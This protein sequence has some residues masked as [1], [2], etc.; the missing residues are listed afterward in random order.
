M[1]VFILYNSIPYEGGYVYGVYSTKL[2]ALL[3]AIKLPEWTRFEIDIEET[4]LDT[5]LELTI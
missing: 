5:E 2:N 4:E 3:A 1:K